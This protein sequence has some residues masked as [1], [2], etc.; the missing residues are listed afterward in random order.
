MLQANDERVRDEAAM[1]ELLAEL[2]AL[3]ELDRR[4]QG[5]VPGTPAFEAA[6]S[7]VD[8]RANR[9]MDRFRDVGLLARTPAEGSRAQGTNL[10][11]GIGGTGSASGSETGAKL[12]RSPGRAHC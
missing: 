10:D 6:S 2:D 5:Y 9:V 7:E 11:E 12:Q 8:A 3:R 1:R 4:R